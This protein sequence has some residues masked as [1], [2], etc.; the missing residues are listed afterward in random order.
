MLVAYE[1]MSPRA[2]ER[3]NKDLKKSKIL[4][5][6]ERGRRKNAQKMLI[7]KCN[8]TYFILTASSDFIL[9]S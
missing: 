4:R 1:K 9:P 8:N 6:R 7:K 2:F 5:K 3:G